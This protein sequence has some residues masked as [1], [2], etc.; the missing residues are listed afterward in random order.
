[1]M[2]C[3]HACLSACLSTCLSACLH[4]QGQGLHLPELDVVWMCSNAASAAQGQHVAAAAGLAR[5]PALRGLLTRLLGRMAGTPS[6][7]A[8]PDH[9]HGSWLQSDLQLP[10]TRVLPAALLMPMDAGGAGS[11]SPACMPLGSGMCS[12]SCTPLA[13]ALSEEDQLAGQHGA[14]HGAVRCAP[15][16]LVEA[17]ACNPTPPVAGPCNWVHGSQAGQPAAGV[18]QHAGA[19]TLADMALCAQQSLVLSAQPSCTS[20]FTM[21]G[22]CVYQVRISAPHCSLSGSAPPLPPSLPACMACMHARARWCRDK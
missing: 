17:T 9:R 10:I 4:A 2:D 21:D 16:V 11:P 3:M 5:D 18:A 12:V 8:L 1:M 15:V 19:C 14:T 13:L 22:A 20:V 7:A 6:A